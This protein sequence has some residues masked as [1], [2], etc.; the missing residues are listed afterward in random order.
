MNRNEYHNAIRD[1]LGLDIDVAALL[2]SDDRSYGFD[3]IGDM[4]G[5]SPTLL[6]GYLEAAR[7][8]S[9]EAVGDPT[10]SPR[11]LHLQLAADLTQ[12]HRL[13]GLPFGTRGGT[14]VKHLFP[15][16]ASTSIKIDLLRNFIGRHHGD[17]RGAP[18]RGERSTAMQVQSFTVG[19]RR[20][21]PG[22]DGGQDGDE[23][24]RN[25]PAVAPDANLRVQ[26]L[27]KAGEREVQVT[28]LQRPSSQSEDLREPYLRSF[29][30]AQRSDERAA[31]HRQHRDQRT[32][33]CRRRRHADQAAHLHLPPR[34]GVGRE[35]VRAE[36]LVVAGAA[37]V[38]SPGHR[39]DL[40]A[41]AGVL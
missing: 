34:A 31:A 15:S 23:G 18:A 40:A 11:D 8:I 38:P 16:T 25:R 14:L 35:R 30:V 21:R 6:E 7:K 20:P 1:L 12:D 3:N 41:A 4:L 10:I 37:R 33:Q 19:G 5:I 13:D 24:N 28:F 39:R 32:A 29:A 17:G 36:D 26:M 2:P 27:V 22:G 9:Q